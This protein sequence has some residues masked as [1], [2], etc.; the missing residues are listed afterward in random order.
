MRTSETSA[1]PTSR[2]D[3]AQRPRGGVVAGAYSSPVDH[4][5]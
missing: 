5:S 2:R 4:S 3:S 1:V